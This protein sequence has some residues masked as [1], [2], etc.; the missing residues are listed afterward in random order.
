M[1]PFAEMRGEF[2]VTSPRRALRC[3]QR[4]RPLLPPV[5]LRREQLRVNNCGGQG[6]PDA[7]APSAV[8]VRRGASGACSCSAARSAPRGAPKSP[9]SHVFCCWVPRVRFE[10]ALG[11]C[12]AR[13][14]ALPAARSP[15]PCAIRRA[16]KAGRRFPLPLGRGCALS[17]RR[18][19][20][21]RSAPPP[22]PPR[23]LPAFR[24]LP[25]PRRESGTF[26]RSTLRAPRVSVLF[27]FPRGV[28]RCGAPPSSG[29][30][31]A[32]PPSCAF[33]L[34]LARASLP[35]FLPRVLSPFRECSCGV[36]PPAACS[37]LR[38]VFSAAR[39]A[40]FRAPP[41]FLPRFAR[42]VV[43][44]PPR[45]ARERAGA[46]VNAVKVC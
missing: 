40:P 43:F 17:R 9:S 3:P 26:T 13:R 11:A 39:S 5:S 36:F 41:R 6:A 24:G 25:P 1:A 38:A 46:C 34:P 10:I 12:S 15:S 33:S 29:R 32:P 30:R 23:G 2:F 20:M 31:Y 27:S 16:R 44:M 22:T 18:A 42:R 7:R 37:A 21:L 19:R 4:G 45:R 8:W 28:R 14:F 35:A